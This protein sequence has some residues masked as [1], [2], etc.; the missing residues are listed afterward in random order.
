[1]GIKQAKQLEDST[2]PKQPVERKANQTE[3]FLNKAQVFFPYCGIMIHFRKRLPSYSFH[4]LKYNTINYHF[5][6]PPPKSIFTVTQFVIVLDYMKIIMG[7]LT[8]GNTDNTG[9]FI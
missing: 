5:A 6:A 1:M 9:I 2:Y 8:L 7:C 3:F 4:F